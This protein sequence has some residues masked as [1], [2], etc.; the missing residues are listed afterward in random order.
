MALSIK[1]T[2]LLLVKRFTLKITKNKK[3]IK[4]V[5]KKTYL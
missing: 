4:F 5:C 3:K 2:K 1:C